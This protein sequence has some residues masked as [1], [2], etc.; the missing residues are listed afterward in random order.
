MRKLRVAI[1]APSLDILGGQSIQADLLLRAWR[2]DPDVEAWLVPVNPPIPAPLRWTKRV[3]YVRTAATECVYIPGLLRDLREAD[4]VHAFSASYWSFLLAPVP[5]IAA[6]KALGRPVVLNYHSGEAPDHLSRSAVARSILGRV[7]RN[8]VPSNFLVRTFGQFH[9]AATAIPNVVDLNQFTYRERAQVAPKIL[10]TRNFEALYNVACTVRAFRLIQD[11]HPDAS[12]TLAGGGS[13]EASL[14]QL[15]AELDLRNVTFVGRV[16][17]RRVA[18]LH[19]AHDVYLQSPNIDN[20][21]LSILQAFA[22]GLPVVTTDAGGIP[23]L[24]THRSTGLMASVD[25]HEG[26]AAHVL[27]LV[28]NPTMASLLAQAAAQTL[29]QFTW[30]IVRPQWLRLYE[31]VLAQSAGKLS[32]GIAPSVAASAD[33]RTI[34]R[35]P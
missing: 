34:G 7:D 2:G 26:L 12:L 19:A 20:M 1:V 29:D 35:Q 4:L 30:E 32:I 9:L 6:A 18:D 22:S 17:P 23:D 11:R 28:T 33:G 27:E 5:A 15:V 25:D 31:S 21:P 14:R 10:S 24:V 16:S 3:K 8:V 13:R